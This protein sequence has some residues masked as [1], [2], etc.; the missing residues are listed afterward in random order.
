MGMFKQSHTIK[1]LISTRAYPAVWVGGLEVWE[2]MI[3]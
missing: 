2:F 1:W 3:L